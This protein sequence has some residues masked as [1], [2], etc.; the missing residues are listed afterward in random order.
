MKS[1]KDFEK[2][3]IGYSDIG[4]LI[5]KNMDKVEI[6][7][8]PCDGEYHAYHVQTLSCNNVK[9]PSHYHKVM[10]GTGE[11]KIYDDKQLTYR[12]ACFLDVKANHWDIYRAGDF[13]CIIHWHK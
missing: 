7:H 10:S 5:I 1:Y 3:Y 2:I 12:Q 6:L 9:I 8:F 11:L 4:D 13:G